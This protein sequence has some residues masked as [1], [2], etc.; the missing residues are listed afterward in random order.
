MSSEIRE[1]ITDIP[2]S[3]E[4]RTHHRARLQGA[5]I[6]LIIFRFRERPL[7]IWASA[8]L[9]KVDCHRRLRPERLQQA[10]GSAGPMESTSSRVTMMEEESSRTVK[11]FIVTF[12]P[13]VSQ[14]RG[15]EKQQ[16]RN[17][18]QSSECEQSSRFW[19]QKNKQAADEAQ[20]RYGGS[21]SSGCKRLSS[22]SVLMPN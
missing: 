6:K 20:V 16:P 3:A 22:N 2:A 19:G 10:D 18:L 15:S 17:I 1:P 4:G 7:C 14:C 11:V 13:I 9:R 8:A 12:N 21:S 5:G